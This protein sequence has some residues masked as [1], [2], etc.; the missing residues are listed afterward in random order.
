MG[1]S[2]IVL[3]L[4]IYSVAITS[5][6]NTADSLLVKYL[7]GGIKHYQLSSILKYKE[8][9][10]YTELPQGSK[11]NRFRYRYYNKRLN[12]YVANVPVLV[13]YPNGVVARS[14]LLR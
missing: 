2:S 3:G 10:K 6:A 8:P 11:G 1:L 14:I 13:L 7:T 9:S 4:S 5:H 12:R